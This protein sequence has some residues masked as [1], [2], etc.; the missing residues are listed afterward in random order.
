MLHFYSPSIYLQLWKKTCILQASCPP[1]QDRYS[2]THLSVC[3]APGQSTVAW[4]ARSREEMALHAVHGRALGHQANAVSATASLLTAACLSDCSCKSLLIPGIPWSPG[5]PWMLL[6][7]PRECSVHW[8][9]FHYRPLEGDRP[10]REA[11]SPSHPI[12]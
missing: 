1:L 5:G 2:L 3:P 4:G 12:L 11:Q 10:Q 8:A 7:C 9:Q 6:H